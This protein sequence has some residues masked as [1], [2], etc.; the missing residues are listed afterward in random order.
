MFHLGLFTFNP[1]G[2]C[3]LI[4][5]QQNPLESVLSYIQSLGVW[6]HEK[7]WSSSIRNNPCR[8]CWQRSEFGK[9]Q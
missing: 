4:S 3:V 8:D 6:A 2:V 9:C 1:F 5:Y 7:T